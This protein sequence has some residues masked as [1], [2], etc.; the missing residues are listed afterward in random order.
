MTRETKRSGSNVTAIVPAKLFRFPDKLQMGHRS[1]SLFCKLHFY[2][3]EIRVLSNVN[4]VKVPREFTLLI[5]V[6]ANRQ[7]CFS[8]FSD[9]TAITNV[10]VFHNVITLPYLGNL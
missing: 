6:N 2:D 9:I 5:V 4:F 8:G 3:F 1:L 10:K 7:S